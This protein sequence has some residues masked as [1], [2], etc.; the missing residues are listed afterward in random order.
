MINRSAVILPMALLL[1][2]TASLSQTTPGGRLSGL[3]TVDQQNREQER[4]GYVCE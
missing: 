3:S 1:L 2:P 4:G